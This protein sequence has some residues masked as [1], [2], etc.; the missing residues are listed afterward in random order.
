MGIVLE[1]ITL[2]TVKDKMKAE[3]GYIN[4]SEIRQNTVQAVVDTGAMRARSDSHLK[5]VELSNIF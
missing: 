2:K 1:E 5:F 4:E 3:E